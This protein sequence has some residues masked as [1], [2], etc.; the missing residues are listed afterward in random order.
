M[1]RCPTCKRTFEDGLTYCLVDG[2]VLSEPFEDEGEVDA[3]ATEVLPESA[4]PDTPAKTIASP[5]RITGPAAFAPPPGP[6]AKVLTR[7]ESKP[8]LLIGIIGLVTVLYSVGIVLLLLSNWQDVSDYFG[9][10]LLRRSP[11]FLIFFIGIVFALARIRHH[12]RASLMVVLAL[13]I[14]VMQGLFF[15]LFTAAVISM[16]AK[17]K[18]SPAA[19]EWLYFFMYFFEDFIYAAVI[20]LLVAAAFTGRNQSSNLTTE[21]T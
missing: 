5:P 7:S 21:T 9:W 1:K 8:L 11:A 13:I 16:L 19:S 4:R 6:P 10:V 20:I 12:M 18:V 17:M 3:R 15:Y 2:S 14:E